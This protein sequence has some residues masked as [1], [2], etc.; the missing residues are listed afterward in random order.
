MTSHH[1]WMEIHLIT[2]GRMVQLEKEKAE[3]EKEKAEVEKEKAEVER[4]KTKLEEEKHEREKALQMSMKENIALKKKVEDLEVNMESAK[5]F[6][7]EMEKP[8]QVLVCGDSH[9]KCISLPKLCQ[10]TGRNIEFVKSFCSRNDWPRAFKPEISI[11]ST[12]L[13]QVDSRATD[14]LITS[15]TSDLTNLTQMSQSARV[16]WI[17]L[18]AK[19]IINTAEI[20]LTRFPALKNVTILEHLPR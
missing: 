4:E 14:L 16:H 2:I 17:D 3:L 15:P 8:K 18:S 12:L 20:C 9:L 10:V 5:Q 1:E 11:V 13:K 6:S 19:T 7:L